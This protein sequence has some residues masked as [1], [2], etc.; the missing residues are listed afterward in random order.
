V[1]CGNGHELPDGF[2]PTDGRRRP[3]PK[4]ATTTRLHA[5]TL[6]TTVHSRASLGFKHRRPGVKRAITEGVVGKLSYS[7]KTRRWHVI[8]R[9]IDRGGDRYREQVV[10]AETGELIHKCDEPL[11]DHQG[12]GSARRRPPS[13]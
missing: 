4:C 3:C 1:K 13:S 2:D 5:I 8:D 12:R 9:L 11:S 6:Q 10:D 7:H